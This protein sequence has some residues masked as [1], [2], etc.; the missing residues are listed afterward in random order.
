[1]ASRLGIKVDVD[2]LEGFCQGVPALMGLLGDHAV[3]AS[4]FLALGLVMNI[5]HQGKTR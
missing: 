4:F 5:H 2:T 1:M 3:K